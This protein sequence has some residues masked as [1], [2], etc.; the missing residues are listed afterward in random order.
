MKRIGI[1]CLASLL[2][3]ACT[4]M[5]GYVL[6]DESKDGKEL[7][8]LSISS[9]ELIGS[10]MT[11]AGETE[12]KDPEQ[13]L[14]DDIYENVFRKGL[15]DGSLIEKGFTINLRSVNNPQLVYTIKYVHPDQA[16]SDLGKENSED[17]NSSETSYA[18]KVSAN[19]FKTWIK[20]GKYKVEGGTS[21]YDS[22]Y[23]SGAISG[24]IIEIKEGEKTTINLKLSD[25]WKALFFSKKSFTLENNVVQND[26]EYDGETYYY[27][28]TSDVDVD[29]LTTEIDSWKGRKFKN[30]RG[31]KRGNYYYLE[32][33]LKEVAS[34]GELG[35]VT[36]GG[37]VGNV[38]MKPGTLTREEK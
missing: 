30:F 23:M 10:P 24:G 34:E 16:E 21:L 25:F 19:L 17:V 20:A 11:R 22:R 14:G 1:L 7:V 32:Y 31:I 2:L 8:Y 12:A 29:S 35:E 3:H 28:F 37:L 13:Q 33:A 4:S 36:V 27:T 38:N 9:K 6:E 5:D 26:I 18:E 15:I